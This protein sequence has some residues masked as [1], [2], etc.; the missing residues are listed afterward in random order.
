MQ[1]WLPGNV[2]TPKSP[3]NDSAFAGDLVALI[4]GLRSA[5][6]KGGGFSGSGRGGRLS[7]HDAWMEKCFRESESLLDAP[8]LRAMWSR[9]RELPSAGPDVMSHKDLTPANLL[10]RGGRL[11]GVLDGGGYG[12]AD[13]AL[14]LVAAWHLLDEKPRHILRHSLGCTDIEWARGTAWAL[15]QSMRLVWYYR[16]TNPK[17]S[18]LGRSTLQRI[19]DS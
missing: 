16:E 7:S 10:V 17:M 2:A 6:T 9:L 12:P 14:D 8:R 4:K 11:A 13:P 1:S 5:D 15:E 3:G 18:E 19:L